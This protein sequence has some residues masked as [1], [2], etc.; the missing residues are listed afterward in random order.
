VELV[1]ERLGDGR[2]VEVDAAMLEA[3]QRAIGKRHQIVDAHLRV[4]LDAHNVEIE[5][6]RKSRRAGDHAM[7]PPLDVVTEPRPGALGPRARTISD[8]SSGIPLE[9]HAHRDPD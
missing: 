7:V 2:A 3:L 5:V 9:R 6:P 8:G 4:I 1:A